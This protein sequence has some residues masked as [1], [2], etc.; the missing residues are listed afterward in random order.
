[1]IVAIEKNNGVGATGIAGI[2]GL[3][4]WEV[5]ANPNRGP[6]TDAFCAAW[7]GLV[8][9]G[10]YGWGTPGY[11]QPGQTLTPPPVQQPPGAAITNLASPNLE[12]ATTNKWKNQWEEWGEIAFGKP[13]PARGVESGWGWNGGTGITGSVLSPLVG[14]VLVVGLVVWYAGRR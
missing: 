5:C 3:G 12:Q 14:I 10:Q 7:Q 6:A 13:N 4:S 8:D 1:M 9:F 11:L 2:T